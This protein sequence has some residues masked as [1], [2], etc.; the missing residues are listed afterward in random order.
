MT[1][2][3]DDNR[4]TRTGPL[5]GVTIGVRD[6]TQR[7]VSKTTPSGPTTTR[8]RD[9]VGRI[10][11]RTDNSSAT[12]VTTWDTVNDCPTC[13]GSGIGYAAR[14]L[15]SSPLRGSVGSDPAQVFSEPSKWH[16]NAE[17]DGVRYPS[18]GPQGVFSRRATDRNLS[19]HCSSSSTVAGGLGPSAGARTRPTLVIT[20]EQ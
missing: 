6:A 13:Q 12:W 16:D 20:F 8:T 3:A 4:L 15:D 5:G 2:D 14:G 11:A 1:Y 19:T 10:P 18:P 7:T 17:R 9:L